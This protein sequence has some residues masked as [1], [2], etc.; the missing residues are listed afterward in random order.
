MSHP[1]NPP[2]DVEAHAHVRAWWENRRLHATALSLVLIAAL[3][4]YTGLGAAVAR[5]LWLDEI[6][7]TL[8][9]TNRDGFW[10]GVVAGADFQPPLPYLLMRLSATVVGGASPVAMRL[11]SVLAAVLAA[12]SLA[13]LL[14]RSLSLPATLA[15][16][17]VLVAHPLFL[18]QAFE[19]RPYALWILATLW[20]ASA[21][22]SHHRARTLIA[23]L[24]AA[25]LVASHY[26]GVLSLAAIAVGGL[27]AGRLRAEPMR[28]TARTL[29]PLVGGGVAFVALLPLAMAQL[30]ASAGRSWVPPVTGEQARAFL[31][32]PWGW[33]P[34]AALMI[35]GAGV[36]VLRRF[37]RTVAQRLP[38][39]TGAWRDPA[40]LALIATALVPL[41]VLAVSVLYK[42][43]LVLRY[44]APATLA[45]AT[46][47]AL[48]VECLPVA[49]R[50]VAVLLLVRALDFS[51][52]SQVA[53]ARLEREQVTADAHT[54]RAL[55]DAGIPSVSPFRHD[56]YRLARWDGDA[57][58][59]WTELSDSL[60]AR[61]SHTS[62]DGLTR[63]FLLVERA[64]GRVVAATFRFPRATTVEAARAQRRIALVRAAEHAASDTVWFPNRTFCA[65]NDRIVVASTAPDSCPPR[66]PADQ[67]T[68]RR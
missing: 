11:P 17:L 56:A 3:A 16:V 33:R 49:A 13:S 2:H 5:P 62:G 54:V 68:S 38:A 40:V 60:L 22:A 6:V 8:I 31:A 1:A 20:T 67:P 44:A 34:A 64:F 25:S 65:I 63:D 55:A 7:G 23:V 58:V 45:I 26:F 35:V 39:Q 19:A 47:T 15:A 4:A 36:I 41:L 9:A 28:A 24:C 10:Q 51:F 30:A 46:L 14:R 61:A 12:V 42:P 52:G 57:D 66:L 48:A 18:S 27:V 43:V 50:Y 53:A 21:L 59:A 32:F 37:S 29:A